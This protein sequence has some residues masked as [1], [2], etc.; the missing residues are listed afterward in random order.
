MM[1]ALPV[2]IG[3]P[4]PVPVPDMKLPHGFQ[5][6]ALPDMALPIGAA[7]PGVP[8]PARSS[9]AIASRAPARYYAA[10]DAGPAI[11]NIM[12]QRASTQMG[13][14]TGGP[15]M[16]GPSAQRA[17]KFPADTQRASVLASREDGMTANEVHL[18][19]N[20]VWSILRRRLALEADRRGKW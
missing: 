16:P 19:A 10:V 5:T 4:L 3:L 7:G 14:V 1:A 2:G 11:R 8:I 9:T 17:Q 20:D 6:Q 12:V 18:L 15:Q 13:S